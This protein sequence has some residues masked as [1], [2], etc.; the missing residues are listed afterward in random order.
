MHML[1]RIL[2]SLVV[3]VAIGTV[4]TPYLMASLMEEGKRV[5]TPFLLISVAM[6]IFAVAYAIGTIRHR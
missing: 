3:G 1:L 6:L 4:A 2:I 5:L